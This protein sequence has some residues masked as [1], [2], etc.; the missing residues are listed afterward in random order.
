MTNAKRNDASRKTALILD[1]D[2]FCREFLTEVLE[3]FGYEVEAFPNPTCFLNITTAEHCPK[4][5]PCFDVIITDNQMPEMT[6]MEFLARLKK[7]DCKIPDTH[8]AILSGSLVG[9][10]MINVRKLGCQAFQKPFQM[11]PFSRWINSLG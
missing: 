2:E 8:K 4:E 10:D 6:G 5:A 7:M 1:D 3:S 11:A 9:D